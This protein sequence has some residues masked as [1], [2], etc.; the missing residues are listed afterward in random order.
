M[1][2][3]ASALPAPAARVFGFQ[4]RPRSGFPMSLCSFPALP[5]PEQQATPYQHC[6]RGQER[7]SP[8]AIYRVREDGSTE[9]GPIVAVMAVLV[10]ALA[11]GLFVWV[12]GTPATAV[13]RSTTTIVQPSAAPA[14][15]QPVSAVLPIPVPGPAGPAGAPGASGPSGAS[16]PAGAAGAAGASGPTGPAGAPEPAVPAEIPPAAPAGR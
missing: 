3:A 5:L 10:V 12:Q 6:P 7:E 2:R 11:V 9:W 15:P 4:N 13:D 8:M 14:A 1:A 16:G